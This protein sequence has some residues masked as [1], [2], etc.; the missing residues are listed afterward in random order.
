M[1]NSKDPSPEAVVLNRR[2]SNKP[3]ARFNSLTYEDW[4]RYV[5]VELPAFKSERLPS[6]YI[7][8]IR[9]SGGELIGEHS[10]GLDQEWDRARRVASAPRQHSLLPLVLINSSP[11]NDKEALSQVAYFASGSSEFTSLTACHGRGGLGKSMRGTVTVVD[12]GRST[13]DRG[14]PSAQC[15][16]QL[17]SRDPTH[18]DVAWRLSGPRG[19]PMFHYTAMHH[20][21]ATRAQLPCESLVAKRKYSKVQPGIFWAAGGAVIRKALRPLSAYWGEAEVRKETMTVYD[22]GVPYGMR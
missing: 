17:Q 1:S 9:Y 12:L 15:I 21:R 16:P 7:E 20:D 14:G 19:T 5:S 18:D 22:D 4:N 6:L 8:R 10:P 3:E 2:R 13:K 11:R